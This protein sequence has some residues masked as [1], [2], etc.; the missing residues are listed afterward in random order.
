V[1]TVAQGGG[2]GS[3]GGGANVH[4]V[5]GTVYMGGTSAGPLSGTSVRDPGVNGRPMLRNDPRTDRHDADIKRLLA[6]VGELEAAH[7]STRQW[8]T[9]RFVTPDAIASVPRAVNDLSG[10]IIGEFERA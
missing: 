8:A 9:R 7:Q 3:G 1:A 4:Q 5:L 2:G 10:D 6:S